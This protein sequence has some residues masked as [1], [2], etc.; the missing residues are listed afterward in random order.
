[1]TALA[2]LCNTSTVMELN[3]NTVEGLTGFIQHVFQQT[4]TPERRAM[5]REIIDKKLRPVIAQV[6]QADSRCDYAAM[7]GTQ[8]HKLLGKWIETSAT[9]Y[10]WNVLVSSDT[11]AQQVRDAFFPESAPTT[12]MAQC[13]DSC[14]G[15]MMTPNRLR[16]LWSS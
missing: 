8:H 7:L 14:R 1:M 2:V 16:T 3:M 11:V 15:M 9:A 10:T 12:L 4:L 13:G 5:A 6:E